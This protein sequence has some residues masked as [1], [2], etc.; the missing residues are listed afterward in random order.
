MSTLGSEI[1]RIT[2]GNPGAVSL[3]VRV[4]NKYEDWVLPCFL[5][6]LEK[7]KLYGGEIWHF[8]KLDRPDNELTE[9]DFDN[10]VKRVWSGAP[11]DKFRRKERIV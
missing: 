8:Y 5:Y 11:I 1:F 10:F 4:M 9:L 6:D 3:L 7:L 2:K